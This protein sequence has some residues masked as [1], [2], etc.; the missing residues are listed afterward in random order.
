MRWHVKNHQC[1]NCQ[2]SFATDK[3]LRRH[4][5]QHT[6][7]KP[8]KCEFAGCKYAETGF[9]RMDNLRRHVKKIHD[10]APL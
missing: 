7:D 4:E 10:N 8:F 1:E 9:A 3:D 2:K 6:G 5:K